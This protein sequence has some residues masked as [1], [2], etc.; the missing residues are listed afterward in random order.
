MR[1]FQRFA[2]AMLDAAPGNRI[3]SAGRWQMQAPMSKRPRAEPIPPAFS[4]HLELDG[5]EYICAL[6]PTDQGEPSR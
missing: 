1:E 3:L 4:M 2:Q 5:K 6:I